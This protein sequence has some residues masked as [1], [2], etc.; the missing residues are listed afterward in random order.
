MKTQDVL[1]IEK[2][3]K[4]LLALVR[5]LQ[6]EKEAEQEEI[7]RNWNKLFPKKNK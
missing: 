1:L 2:P 6:E 7:K 5:K 4:G 3:S